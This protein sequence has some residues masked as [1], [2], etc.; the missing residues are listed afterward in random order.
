MTVR[1][2]TAAS[3]SNL[4]VLSEAL[5]VLHLSCLGIY[6][7]VAILNTIY[8]LTAR[9]SAARARLETRLSEEVT[10]WR[11]ENFLL[12]LTMASETCRVSAQPQID[13]NEQMAHGRGG[14]GMEN[15]EHGEGATLR[16]QAA[17]Q[18]QQCR[19]PQAR[20]G[21]HGPIT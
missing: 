21:V 3:W 14:M 12:A 13:T 15:E 16:A 6:V 2:I 18:S 20:V 17:T 9:P 10:A 11:V 8:M 7:E 19:R 4:G 5:R 1:F